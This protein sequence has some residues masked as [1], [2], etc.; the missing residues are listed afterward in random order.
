[1]YDVVRGQH[2]RC[3]KMVQQYFV[4]YSEKQV[5]CLDYVALQCIIHFY[6]QDGLILVRT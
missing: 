2:T 5:A 4:F 1:M 3:V 6:V